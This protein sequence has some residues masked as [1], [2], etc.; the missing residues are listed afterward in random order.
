MAFKKNIQ[1]QYGIPCEYHIIAK[2]EKDKISKSA[3][4]V[5]YSYPSKEARDSG[6]NFLERRY[7]NVYPNDYDSVFGINTLNQ[8]GAND[9]KNMYIFIKQHCE[10]F[11]DA[12]I[13]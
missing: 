2:I 9:Y 4:V 8:E 7:V 13:S 1:T 11:N 5:L 6:A 3:F 10:D 12:E